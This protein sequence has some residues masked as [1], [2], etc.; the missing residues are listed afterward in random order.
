M[1]LYAKGDSRTGGFGQTIQANSALTLRSDIP[2]AIVFRALGV[3][4]DEDILN[5]ICYDRKDS[6]ML[7]MLRAMY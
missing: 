4:S 7:E 5:H 1:K 2:I 3:V 6:Q